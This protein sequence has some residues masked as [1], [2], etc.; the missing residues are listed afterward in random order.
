MCER[1]T[2][3]VNSEAPKWRGGLT[4]ESM[5]YHNAPPVNSGVPSGIL[6]E[7][8]SALLPKL[9]SCVTVDL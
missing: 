6:N 9:T 4:W 8:A 2:P 1:R 7:Y 3:P 5:R